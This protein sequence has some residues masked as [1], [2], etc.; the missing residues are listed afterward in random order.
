MNLSF[1]NIAWDFKDNDKI[2]TLLE[3]NG[4]RACE[5]APTIITPEPFTKNVHK[6]QTFREEIKSKYRLDISSMQSIWFGRTENIFNPEDAE[7]LLDYTKKIIDLSSLI[8]CKNLVFGCPKNRN[9]PAG[10]SEDQVVP[11][12]QELGNYAHSKNTCI[13]IEANPTIYHTNFINTTPEAFSFAKKI[14]SPG[15][16]VNVDLG[17]IIYNNESLDP[18]KSHPELINHVHISEPN[19]LPITP[20]SLHRELNELLQ[21]IGYQKYLSVE[22]KNPIKTDIIESIITYISKTF[23]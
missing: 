9:L 23:A 12:F 6:V 22:M 10:C 2:C 11:F 8:D 16:K 19:L 4:F 5:I 21:T 20:R 13:A 14:N 7:I 1:S 3:K 15:I 17:T 18:L